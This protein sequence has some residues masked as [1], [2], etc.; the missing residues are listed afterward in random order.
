[1]VFDWLHPYHSH[2]M[3]FDWL[4]PYHSH[5]MMFDWLRPYQLLT[6]WKVDGRMEGPLQVKRYQKSQDNQP[7]F[8]MLLPG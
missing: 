3:M 4:H 2:W 1:M 7:R 8:Q 5:W 6:A